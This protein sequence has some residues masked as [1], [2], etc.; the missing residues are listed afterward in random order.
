[1]KKAFTMLELIMV[2]VIIGILAAVIIPRTGSNNT[3][4]AAV[5]LISDIRYTQHLAMID[6]KYGDNVGIPWYQKLWQIRF[7]GNTYSIRSVDTAGNEFFA[8]DPMENNGR[9]QNIDLNNK[10]GVTLTPDANCSDGVNNFI[11]FDHIG[12][13]MVGD[14][15]GTSPYTNLMTNNCT[16]TISGDGPNVIL[17]IRPET[18][19]VSN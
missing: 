7:N 9:M 3:A 5:K 14:I 4:E 6:D 2:I 12:R 16:I 19:Y 10:F 17:T 11:A 1:M 18:G 13:P 15:N 8:V